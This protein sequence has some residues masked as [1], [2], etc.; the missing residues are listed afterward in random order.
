MI[1]RFALASPVDCPERLAP[2]PRG[3]QL[4]SPRPI[5]YSVVYNDIFQSYTSKA[6]WRQGMALLW[7]VP[8][9]QHYALSSY[10]LT[11]A[12]LTILRSTLRYMTLWHYD[13]KLKGMLHQL[14]MYNICPHP[15]RRSRRCT[16]APASSP[17]KQMYATNTKHIY[18]CYYYYYYYYYYYFYY[19]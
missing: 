2:T 1:I 16:T 18:W 7:G 6:I 3:R 10:A 14:I 5:R 13:M 17:P 8:M 9:F 11:C 12:L 15:P 19:Y 4:D